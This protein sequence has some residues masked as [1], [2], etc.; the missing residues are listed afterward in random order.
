M[1]AYFWV[2]PCLQSMPSDTESTTSSLRRVPFVIQL[3]STHTELS[4]LA[5]CSKAERLIRKPSFSCRE[6]VVSRSSRFQQGRRASSRAQL[7]KS[8]G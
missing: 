6:D 1:Q 2:H 3:Q 5:S 7:S 4:I 8:P